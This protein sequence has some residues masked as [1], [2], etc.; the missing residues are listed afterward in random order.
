MSA[1]EFDLIAKHFAPLA[2]HR[3]ARGLVDDVAVIESQTALVVT[4][5]AIV[6]GVHFLGGDPLDTVARKAVRVNFSDLIAKGSK[7]VGITL[8]LIWPHGRDAAEIAELARGLGEDLTYY[9]AALFGGDTTSTSGPL[10]ISI[11]A[12]GAPYGSRTPSRADAKVGDQ[13]WVTG[14]IGDAV[15]GLQSLTQSPAILGA[16]AGDNIEAHAR[17]VQIAYRVPN[18]PL[19][20]AGAIAEYASA[21]MDI[22]DGLVGDAAKI[23]AASGVGIRLDAESIPLSAAGHAYVSARGAEGLVALITGGDDYQALFM[24]EPGARGAIMAA[25]RAAETN[26]ALIGDV[27]QGQ[28]VRVVSGAGELKIGAGGHRHKLGR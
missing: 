16:N 5:D 8:S 22:S 20:F 17:A 6:E 26:V 24:A 9:N 2:Q 25:A 3:F 7:P 13:V 14:V 23:A 4:T 11:T 15:L 27:V 28:G 10:T 12:F 1:D 19:S 21:S 18:P